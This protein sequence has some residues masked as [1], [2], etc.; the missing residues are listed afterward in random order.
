LPRPPVGGP[1]KRYSHHSIKQREG[2]AA[3]QT[4]F[5]VINAEVLLYGF[6]QQRDNLA[7]NKSRGVASHKDDNTKPSAAWI[8]PD[9]SLG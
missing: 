4:E 2:K 7:V 5:S 6:H 8:W 9:G 3:E 1:R